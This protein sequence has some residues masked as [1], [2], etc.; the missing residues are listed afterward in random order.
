MNQIKP[1]SRNHKTKQTTCSSSLISI[2]IHKQTAQS[3]MGHIQ[4]TKKTNKQTNKK[5]IFES[6]RVP[7]NED[8][9]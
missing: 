6:V 2:T 1:T 8:E 3:Q 4:K 9:N 5:E 7:G